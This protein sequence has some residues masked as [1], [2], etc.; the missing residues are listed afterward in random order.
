MDEATLA[1]LRPRMPR[2]GWEGWFVIT[3][4]GAAARV[5]WTK[6]HVFRKSGRPGLRALA[7]VEGLDAPGEVVSFVATGDRVHRFDRRFEPGDLGFGSTGWPMILE[8]T[9]RPELDWRASEERM[10]FRRTSGAPGLDL[11]VEIERHA[12]DRIR[13][14]RLPPLLTYVSRLAQATG[15]CAIEGQTQAI[16]GLALVEHAFGSLVHFDP[17]RLIRGPWQWDVLSFGDG[18]GIAALAI[19][20]PAIGLRGVRAAGRIPGESF[21]S[22]S[23]FALETAR[24]GA[25]QSWRGCMRDRRGGLLSYEAIA[26]TPIAEASPGVG[27]MGFEFEATYAKR[28]LSGTG[29]TEFGGR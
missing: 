5:R 7:A 4:G 9:D 27:F 6:T 25:P 15:S 14:I 26:K 28:K 11:L 22:F 8:G 19:T 24:T 10:P 1:D 29:F 3:V 16:E 17:M 18:C 23:G 2:A 12:N 13:W 21:R 20:V